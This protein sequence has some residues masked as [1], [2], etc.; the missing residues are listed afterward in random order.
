MSAR[1][2][3]TDR[4]STVKLLK[5]VMSD[6]ASRYSRTEVMSLEK[7]EKCKSGINLPQR[8]I[9]APSLT[10][11]H[12][13]IIKPLLANAVCLIPHCRPHLRVPLPKPVPPEI[14]CQPFCVD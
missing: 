1:V 4:D 8:S 7:A 10:L 12:L 6:D 3:L 11:P 2:F 14:Y 5:I 13:H 9:L